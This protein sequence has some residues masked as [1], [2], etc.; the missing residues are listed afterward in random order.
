M[1]QSLAGVNLDGVDSNSNCDEPQNDGK[2]EN[3]AKVRAE[4]KTEQD[5]YAD[6]LRFNNAVREVFLNRFVH[7]FLAYEKFVILPS[8]VCVL[9]CCV[10][11]V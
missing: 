3:L 11:F 6:D 5:L 2:N 10:H 8:Q 4:P 7:I 9:H 1:K